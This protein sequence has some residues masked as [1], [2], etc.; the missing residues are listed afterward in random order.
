[1]HKQV[2]ILNKNINLETSGVYVVFNNNLSNSKLDVSEKVFYINLPNEN[3]INLSNYTNNKDLSVNVYK[4]LID[5]YNLELIKPRQIIDIFNKLIYAI[6][7]EI[8]NYDVLVIGTMGLDFDSI[9]L[10]IQEL[11]NISKSYKKTFIFVQETTKNINTFE[12]VTQLKL[13]DFENWY[14]NNSIN[15][16]E[17]FLFKRK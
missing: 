4:K 17:T 7:N 9:K 15:N 3:S 13:K 14:I 1:M 2:I 12:K 10:M 6:I 16:N 8:E 5:K 11:I